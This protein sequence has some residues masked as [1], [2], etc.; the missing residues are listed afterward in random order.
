MVFCQSVRVN[1]ETI[2]EFDKYKKSLKNMRNSKLIDEFLSYLDLVEESDSGREFHP[3]QI[4]S[5]RVQLQPSLT[6]VIKEMRNR[7][8]R[9]EL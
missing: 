7:V 5:V 8:K 1:K 9:E 6:A 4:S 3:I 2:E